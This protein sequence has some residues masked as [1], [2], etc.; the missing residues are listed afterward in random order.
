[1]ARGLPQLLGRIIWPLMVVTLVGLAIY[2][3]SGRLAMRAISNAQTEVSAVL[4]SVA[5]GDVSIGA[6]KGEM[7]GFSPRIQIEDLA[8]RDD[9]SGEWLNL[10]SVSIRLDAWASLLSGGLR[11]DEVLLT[12]PVFRAL[13]GPRRQ[14]QPLPP[15]L[16]GFLN[17]FERLV[18]REARL[19]ESTQAETQS[20][21]ARALTLD[22]DMVREGSRRDLKI[23]LHSDEGEV[24]AAEGFGTGDPRNYKKFSGEFHGFVTGDG[25]GLAA[26]A[27][28]V[29][30]AAEGSANFWLSVSQERADVTLQTDFKNIIETGTDRVVLEGV[31]FSAALEGVSDQPHLWIEDLKLAHTDEALLVE[32]LQCADAERGWQCRS[33]ELEIAPLIDL[34]LASEVLPEKASKI[35]ATLNPSGRIEAISVETA[36][37]DQPLENWAASIVVADATTQPYRT[38]PGLGGID[39]SIVANQDGAEAW[40]LTEDFALDLPGVYEVPITLQSVTGVLSGHWQKDALFLED[41]LFLAAAPDHTATV[42][43]EIDIP[44]FKNASIERE[45]RLAVA[46]NKAPVSVRDAYVPKRLPTPA[47]QWL[48]AALPAGYIESAAFLWFGGFRPYGDPSQTMQLA[49]NLRDVTLEYQKQWPQIELAEGFLRLDDT[50]IDIW[51]SKASTEGLILNNTSAGLRLGPERSW[52]QVRAHSESDVSELKQA[53]YGLPPLDFVRPLLGDLTTTGAA[54]TDMRVGFDLRDITQSVEV[55]VD[56]D[57]AS[58]TVDS[59]LLGLTAERISGG[60]SYDTERG[61]ESDD[62]RGVFFGRELKVEMTPELTRTPDVLLAA[63]LNFDLD[64]KDIMTWR[65]VPIALPIDGVIPMEIMVT[66]A[67]QIMVEVASDLEGARIDL[68]RPWGKA[69]EGSA[70]LKLVWHDRGWADW[71]VFWFGRF[72]ATAD[73]SAGELSSASIDLT[74]RTR[75]PREPQ[76]SA[77][78]GIHVTGL[79]PQL[80]LVEWFDVLTAATTGETPRPAITVDKL[81]V[82]QLQ[83]RGQPLGNLNLSVVSDRE[84]FRSD[85]MLPWLRGSYHQQIAAPISESAADFDA[86]LERMLSIER[87]DVS[88]IPDIK[89]P[90]GEQTEMAFSWQPLPVTIRNV[91]RG[92]NR[93]GGIDF[94]VA[95][96][97][98]DRWHLTEVAGDLIGATLLSD[99]Q[100]AWQRSQDVEVTS[101]A[102]AV[103]FNNLGS[104]LESLGVEPIVQTRGGAIDIDWSWTG[105]P[106]LFDLKTVSGSMDLTME[107]GSFVSANAEAAGAMRLLSLMNLAG[108][109]QRANINQLFD[110]GV[111]FDRAAGTIE[112]NQGALRIPGFSVEGSGGYFTLASDIDLREETVDGELVVTLPLV[113][114]IPWVA[115]LA[116]GLPIAAGAY[117]ISKVF[118]EQVNQL[119]SGVYSVSGDLNSPE[120]IF[121]RVFDAEATAPA[122]GIQSSKEPASSSP[123]R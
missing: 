87:L 1:M 100:V 123:A 27:L 75:P 80:D 14:D 12:K 2:V 67:D 110:P 108:L 61:F 5:N 17:G 95:D 121:R 43:F 38:V 36:Q 86:D 115:A 91:Y 8:I 101:L 55:E 85:F 13:P 32:R 37:L 65:S 15:G 6:I 49:A 53:L 26:Q 3:S 74:P 18:I 11:F 73:T 68:P 40:V 106:G 19:L 50:D 48:K 63:Q 28:G 97:Q 56:V 102:L 21:L 46:L 105:S 119:S 10:P 94:T 78:A 76:T 116:G 89:N 66:V 44:F 34:L 60:L 23:S 51:S 30:L 52:L 16:E 104:S 70:P 20:L 42:Q 84:S 92:S 25:L 83:W 58:A 24:F 88:G 59:A 71:E 62:L 64:I 39:A 111:T 82:E 9:A 33:R 109:F 57:F 77:G 107:S 122:L 69:R 29:T 35:L 103:E 79:L 98:S 96:L 93:L 99:S 120:V 117:V 54:S 7:A 81:R 41:G 72:S 113:D 47:Y 90:E 112:F 22:L 31:S 45:M 118:E 4:S 114:N